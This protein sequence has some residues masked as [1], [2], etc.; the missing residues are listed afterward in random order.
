MSGTDNLM[1]LEAASQSQAETD[2]ASLSTALAFDS[3]C[4]KLGLSFSI[5]DRNFKSLNITGSF[6]DLNQLIH[7]PEFLTRWTQTL[8]LSSADNT[9]WIRVKIRYATDLTPVSFLRSIECIAF[10]VKRNWL[11]M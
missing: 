3:I 9:I 6:Q 1:L 8:Y 10:I 4:R 7:S 2:A 11:L 5:F